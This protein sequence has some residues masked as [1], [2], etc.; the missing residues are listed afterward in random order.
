MQFAAKQVGAATPRLSYVTPR[1]TSSALGLALGCYWL[2][3]QHASCSQNNIFAPA[4]RRYEML[5][6]AHIIENAYLVEFYFV[7]RAHHVG[8]DVPFVAKVPVKEQTFPGVAPAVGPVSSTCV[9]PGVNPAD[10]AGNNTKSQ[11]MSAAPGI[12]CC[13]CYR[14]AGARLR[15]FSQ[16]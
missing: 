5:A 16:D 9:Q 6:S 12:A 10:P 14:C 8:Q 4:L 7:S 2:P 3:S 15:K 11:K 13:R 1:E